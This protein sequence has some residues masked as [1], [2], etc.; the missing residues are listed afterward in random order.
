MLLS[1]FALSALAAEPAEGSSADAE[2][3]SVSLTD[4]LE[5]RYWIKPERL[6][7]PADVPVFNY[8]EQVNRFNAVVSRGRWSF[9]AQ[10]DEVALFANR[11]YLDDQ[12]FLERDLV[13]DAV[14]TPLPER[15]DAYTTVEKVRAKYEVDAGSVAVGD[16][17]VAFGRGIALN[18]NR[19]VD[20]DIDTSV[21]GVKTVLRPGA[22]DV[23]AV[24]GQLNRQQVFQDNPNTE[25]QGDYRHAV[26]GVRAERFG[27]GPADIGAHGV[28]Y[29]FVDEIGLGPGFDELGTE[30]DVYVGGLTT[31]LYGVGGIDWYFEGDVF[32][33]GP[34][35]PELSVAEAGDPGYATYASA[36]FYPGKLVFLVEGKRYFQTDRVNA[37]LTP[38]L[39]E[40]AIAPTLEYERAIT[41][42]SAAALNSNDQWGTRIQMDWAAKPGELTPYVAVGVMRD[43]ELGGLH[44]NDV[45]ETI[46]HPMVG[47]EWLAGE[48]SAIINAG[49]RIDDRDGNQAGADQ[50]THADAAIH[51]PVAGLHGQI[52]I[53]AEYYQWGVNPLQQQDYAEL[54]TGWTLLYHSVVG[55][56]WYSDYTT[57]PLVTSTG[58]LTDELYGALEFQVKPTSS[59]TMKLFGGAYKAGIRCSGGQCR[60]LPGFEGARFS[61]T[62][63]F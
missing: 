45:P 8:V 51:F 31:A 16:N 43:N 53:G 18:L 22:W 63:S 27:L 35:Q 36:S 50:Q 28:V 39:Y 5:I 21:Q 2:A 32:G 29:D 42:D 4:D 33:F 52:N 9:D 19:N 10:W 61:L 57:N 37:V 34:D 12:L 48:S 3:W 59:L 41:E 44:F 38:E 11:Y 46:V 7:D 30:P 14:P 40:V 60:T 47:V 13:L 25:I 49:H 58:N 20:I 62:G 23:T 54:E 17:Y 15:W 24:A 56:T 6:F 26:A 1:L 55:V